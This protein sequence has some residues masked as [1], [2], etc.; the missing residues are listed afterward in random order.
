MSF[1]EFGEV[2]EKS[3]PRAA[4]GTFQ[5]FGEVI[6]PVSK[7]RSLIGA[8]LKGGAKKF[9]DIV[10]LVQ[11]VPFPKGELRPEQIREF[12]E[13]KFPTH[14]GELESFL[15]RAGGIGVESLISPGGPL[16]KGAQILGGAALG[17][18]AEKFG[19]PDWAQAIA[20]SLPFFYSGGKKIPLKADQKKLG[21]FLRNQGLTE[22]EI[23]P[24]LKTPEQINRWSSYASKGKKSRELMQAIYNKSG[25]IYD[26]V[27]EEG[28]KFPS[29]S[30]EASSKFMSE[31]REIYGEMPHKYRKLI[32]QDLKDFTRKGRE[33][34]EN[35][36][37]LDQDI[38]SVIGAEKGGRAT[39]GQFKGPIESAMKSISPEVAEDYGL[40][41]RLYATRSDVKGAL[42]NPKDFDKFIDAGEV[43]AL[44]QG[45][46]N[47]DIGMIYKVVGVAA[48]KKLA[49]EMLI[50]PRLQNISVRVG[51]ALKKN[52]LTLA[53]KLMLQFN[54]E[55][56]KEDPDLAESI[57]QLQ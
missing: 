28:K 56:S 38:N 16:V 30:S 46:A 6:E 44:G 9:A 34:I 23:T 22:N 55:L 24:L 29:L 49:R 11:K 5:E 35:L 47:R 37:N 13:E 45:L 25:K 39:V 31:I 1:P 14:E 10:E 32:K 21:E 53:E 54:K 43:F 4:P 19:A 48:G 17:Y 2:V 26:F 27:I 33:G 8:P 12:A 7:V 57:T 15:E 52:N 3:P 36:I 41:K 40:A 18:G 51:E 50:N 20:E 42:V